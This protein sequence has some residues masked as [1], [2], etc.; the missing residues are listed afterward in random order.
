MGAFRT[1]DGGCRLVQQPLIPSVF[2]GYVVD[3][4]SFLLSS[5]ALLAAIGTGSPARMRGMAENAAT[6]LQRDVTA[7]DD[8]TTLTAP[9][10]TARRA[11][12]LLM[13]AEVLLPLAPNMSLPVHRS[14]ARAALVAANCN[15]FVG[16]PFG[17]LLGAAE[18]H[19]DAAHDGPLLGEALLIRARHCGEK[20]HEYD[21]PSDL[22]SR[23]LTRAI[24]VSGGGREAATVRAWCRFGLAWEYAA[25][26]SEI[27]A[28]R[29]LAAGAA[30]WG[31]SPGEVAANRG[32]VL[33]L[34]PGH[35]ADAEASLCAALG[36]HFPPVRSGSALVALARLHLADG[37]VDAAA[38]DLEE[39][40]LTNR[41]AGVRQ[42]RVMGARR[43]LPD[44]LAV[45]ELDAVMYEA[46]A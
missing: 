23:Y 44:C 1:L 17:T 25:E 5:A 19:A 18:S 39:A 11:S 9:A 22:C 42:W 26:G 31:L 34:L 30:E 16:K 21:K 6:R 8:G 10:V 13:D 35:T 37:D 14:A 45:R 40:F 15:R 43:L 20:A 27:T 29:H 33:R 4:R 24:E 32:D 3:R 12:A 36:A 7:L 41:A 38:G 2:T 46:E 28:M